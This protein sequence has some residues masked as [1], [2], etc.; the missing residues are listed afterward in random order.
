MCTILCTD[1]NAQNTCVSAILTFAQNFHHTTKTGLWTQSYSLY[2]NGPH[3]VLIWVIVIVMEWNGQRSCKIC[4]YDYCHWAR[5]SLCITLLYCYEY[6]IYVM[7]GLCKCDTTRPQPCHLGIAARKTHSLGAIY[8]AHTVAPSSN[9]LGMSKTGCSQ[10]S[11]L[12][13]RCKIQR[14]TCN[15]IWISRC[16]FHLDLNLDLDACPSM[17]LHLSICETI[18]F[19]QVNSFFINLDTIWHISAA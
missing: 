17:F 7:D 3:F 6:G 16:M 13:S 9:T 12:S 11:I 1:Y 8:H 5:V 4:I 14:S 18:I 10:N 19:I 15:C 2:N